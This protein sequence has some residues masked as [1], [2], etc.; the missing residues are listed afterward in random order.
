M[1]IISPVAG[2]GGIMQAITLIDIILDAK[3][4][5]YKELII[6]IVFQEILKKLRSVKISSAKFVQTS[7]QFL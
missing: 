6:L 4:S 1:G 2:F 3:N 5:V 7:C